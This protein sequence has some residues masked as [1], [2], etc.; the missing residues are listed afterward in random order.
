MKNLANLDELSKEILDIDEEA[1]RENP[2]FFKQLINDVMNAASCLGSNSTSDDDVS[3]YEKLYTKISIL[4]ESAE[5]KK[6]LLKK[7][8]IKLG[9]SRN[10]VKKYQ[11]I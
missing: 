3:K 8:L 7:D 10:N 1:F 9:K 6:A 11:Q 4:I 2:L 5:N